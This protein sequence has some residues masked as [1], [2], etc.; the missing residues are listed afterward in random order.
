MSE[1]VYV[2]INDILALNSDYDHRNLYLLWSK[3]LVSLL[4]YKY[5]CK[6][7]TICIKNSLTLSLQ[8][9][10]SKMNQQGTKQQ[11]KTLRN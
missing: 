6:L 7:F 2:T 8:L 10:A 9:I 5:I 11:K 1:I 4:L 3:L